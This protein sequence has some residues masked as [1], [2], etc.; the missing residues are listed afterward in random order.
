[1]NSSHVP[2]A[3]APCAVEPCMRGWSRLSLHAG[4][5]TVARAGQT[6]NHHHPGP[7]LHLI[8]FNVYDQPGGINVKAGVIK[9]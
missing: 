6:G 8:L 5:V 9:A 3:R 4:A 1:M 7:I 2:G